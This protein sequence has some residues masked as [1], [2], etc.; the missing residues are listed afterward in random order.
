MKKKTKATVEI[1][2][3]YISQYKC[4]D[5]RFFILKY[6]QSDIFTLLIFDELF[7]IGEV[8]F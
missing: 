3:S 8:L 2:I 6:F 7:T 4:R 5:S 1:S